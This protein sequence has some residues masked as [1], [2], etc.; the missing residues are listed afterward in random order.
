MAWSRHRLTPLTAASLAQ[1]LAWE[2]HWDP[3]RSTISKFCV[4]MYMFAVCM[5]EGQRSSLVFSLIIIQLIPPNLNIYLFTLCVRTQTF[6]SCLFWRSEDKFWESILYFY[7]VSSKDRAQVVKQRPLPSK[8][9]HWPSPP[10]FLRHSLTEPKAH[11][12]AL[13]GWPASD[14]E[15]QGSTCLPTHSPALTCWGYIVSHCVQL[16][17]G[18]WRLNSDPSTVCKHFTGPFPQPQG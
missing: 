14:H 10:Y 11:W 1:C 6:H 2:R 12:F 8:P 18:C 3:Q 9:S 7:H 5:C 15:L 13:A 16:L 17:C 4:C